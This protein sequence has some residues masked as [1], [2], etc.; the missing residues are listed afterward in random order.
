MLENASQNSAILLMCY[1]TAID[2]VSIVSVFS[3]L[4]LQ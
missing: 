2:C 1:S 4:F 3:A